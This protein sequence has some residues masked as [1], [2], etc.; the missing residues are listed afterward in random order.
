MVKTKNSGFFERLLKRMSRQIVSGY[1][2]PFA[3]NVWKNNSGPMA[4]LFD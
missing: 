4:G 3:N 1:R 2:K